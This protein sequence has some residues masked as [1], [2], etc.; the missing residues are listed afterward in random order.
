V[1]LRKVSL[2]TCQVLPGGFAAAYDG[3]VADFCP[4][5]GTVSQAVMGEKPQNRK[6]E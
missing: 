4:F 6:L 3:L 2:E 1:S 5:G